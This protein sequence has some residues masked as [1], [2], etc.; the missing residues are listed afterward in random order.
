MST[1][2]NTGEQLKQLV[3]SCGKGVTIYPFAKIVNPQNIEIGDFSMIDDFTF[4][5]GGEGI[6]IGRYVHIASFV[7]IIGSGELVIGDYADIACGARIL[8]ATDTY[9]EGKR[10]SSALPAEQRNVIRGKITIGK[11]AF[12][13]TNVIIHPNVTIGEGAIIGSNS[14]VLRNVEPWTINSGSPCVKTGNRPKIKL[15]DI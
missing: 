6:K 11:D 7:S 12:I 15:P 1:F 5:N 13:G 4:I 2:E 9:Y 10:M 8:T 3:K 14:L